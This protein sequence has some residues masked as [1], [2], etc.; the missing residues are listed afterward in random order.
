MRKAADVAVRT[1][2]RVSI[3]MCDIQYGKV[4]EEAISAIIPT[5]LKTGLGS[6]VEEV[7]SIRLVGLSTILK[8]V[9]IVTENILERLDFRSLY[10]NFQFNYSCKD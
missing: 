8:S 5:L 1:M 4:G 3:K 2:S 7:R 10:L 9:Q 6:Q